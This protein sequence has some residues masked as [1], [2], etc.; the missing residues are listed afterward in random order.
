MAV[1][2]G[3]RAEHGG[4]V[5][6]RYP[7]GC[8]RVGGLGVMIRWV[9][10]ALTLIGTAACI[11]VAGF[12]VGIFGSGASI[13]VAAAGPEAGRINACR[14]GEKKGGAD[15]VDDL[16]TSDG[17]P[18][19][20]RTP[21]DYD[22]T[23]GYPLLVVYPPA[24]LNRVTS[25]RYYD[26][27]PEATRRGYIVAYS[28]HV[29]LSR[30]AVRMQAKVAQTVMDRW[31][32]DGA[33][34]SFLGH[35]DGGSIAEGTLISQESGS[36]I[37][38]AIV[39]SAAGIKGEDLDGLCRSTPFRLMIVH[40]REDER[41]PGFGLEAARKWAAHEGCSLDLPEPEETGCATFRHCS[42]KSRIDYCET[43]GPHSRWPAIAAAS[44][45]FMGP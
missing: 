41:F 37:P 19:R 31:C 27:T 18:I 38:Y 39:A 2:C 24:G 12:A 42:N 7:A 34:V 17:L 20:V 11:G 40:S 16:R 33:A 3:D 35:S 8:E 1:A 21:E 44:F 36:V 43:S 9:R 14:A 32:V 29:R 13:P 23:R 15:T 6:D 4:A 26:L 28:D 30:A 10:G 5:A 22:P 45:A 25:E